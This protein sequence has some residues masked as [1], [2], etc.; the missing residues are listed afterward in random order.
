MKPPDLNEAAVSGN[1]LATRA[2]SMQSTDTDL[3]NAL[4]GKRWQQAIE[5]AQGRDWLK[6]KALAPA[7]LR[8]RFAGISTP[9]VNHGN[10]PLRHEPAIASLQRVAPILPTSP[11]FSGVAPPPDSGLDIA[12]ASVTRTTVQPVVPTRVPDL[13]SYL[14]QA[15]LGNLSATVLTTSLQAARSTDDAIAKP[16]PTLLQSSAFFSVA[17]ANA[18]TVQMSYAWVH[19]GTGP[20]LHMW[21]G[22]PVAQFAELP[23]LLQGLQTQLQTLDIRLIA[24]TCN[25]QPLLSAF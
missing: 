3:Q 8:S 12:H 10:A 2:T 21:L 16:P 23:S 13:A 7:P 25:G 4:N 19:D 20:G 11:R 6:H 14:T 18:P 17:T 5:A 9:D 24:L 1:Y 22:V 15:G